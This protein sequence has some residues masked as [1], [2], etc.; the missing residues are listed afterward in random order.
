MLLAHRGLAQTFSMEGIT[1][2]TNTAAIIYEPEH[3]YLENTLTSI[4][5][6]FAAGACPQLRWVRNGDLLKMRYMKL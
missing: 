6:A 2:D 3:P 1:G 4:E 5:A